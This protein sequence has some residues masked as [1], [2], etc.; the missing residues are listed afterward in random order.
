MF[1]TEDDHYLPLG[2]LDSEEGIEAL[3]CGG[4]FQYLQI[5]EIEPEPV[6]IFPN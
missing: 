3:S 5:I 4:D 2:P 1:I 6:K